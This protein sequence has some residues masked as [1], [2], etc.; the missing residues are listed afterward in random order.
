MEGQHA[1]CINS[2]RTVSRPSRPLISPGVYALPWS[3]LPAAW[4]VGGCEVELHPVS[5]FE[6][7]TVRVVNRIS[8][9]VTMQVSY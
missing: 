2:G 6:T 5:Y 4:K 1:Y 7:G 9:L 3:S 8:G